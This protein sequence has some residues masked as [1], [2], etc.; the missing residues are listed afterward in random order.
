MTATTGLSKRKPLPWS[1][2]PE[3]RP[4]LTLL[5]T[6]GCPCLVPYE[7]PGLPTHPPIPSDRSRPKPECE[8][9]RC[10]VTHRPESRLPA[11]RFDPL[12]RAGE[13]SAESHSN[14]NAFSVDPTV[15][16]V[17]VPPNLRA[18]LEVR[19]GT[20]ARSSTT[21]RSTPRLRSSRD[22]MTALSA[23][24]PAPTHDVHPHAQP[25]EL[26]HLT[27]CLVS[28][29]VAQ[30]NWALLSSRGTPAA[31]GGPVGDPDP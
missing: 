20:C 16:S 31:F 24:M 2:I 3:C 26:C 1:D 6:I 4:L 30:E 12:L 5:V 21:N 15:R 14:P 7:L 10:C 9:R 28:S 27:R 23:T 8:R 13:P 18:Q 29:Q 17:I 25:G 22:D 19:L 11:L